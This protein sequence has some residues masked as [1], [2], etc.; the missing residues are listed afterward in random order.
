MPSN[1]DFDS[2][3]FGDLV[4]DFL[5]ESTH[6][7]GILND[8]FLEFEEALGTGLP[9]IPLEPNI[10]IFGEVFR[11]AHSIKGTSSML[12]LV[13]VSSFTHA[14][15]N[16]LDAI[17]SAR[18]DLS[19]PLLEIL[20][21]G[22]DR[23]EDML[24][25]V[26]INESDQLTDETDELSDEDRQ[27]IQW[28][29]KAVHE[30]LEPEAVPI[31]TSEAERVPL[32]T[33]AE[34]TSELDERPAEVELAESNEPEEVAVAP[35]DDALASD[36]SP[37]SREEDDQ[38]ESQAAAAHVPPKVSTSST[39]NDGD[40]GFDMSR[41]LSLYL[42]ESDEEIDALNEGLLQLE[43][44]PGDREA[45][46]EVFR[47]AH[48]IKGSATAMG[49]EDVGLV[50]H[51]LEDIFD[52]LRDG[53]G[54]IDEAGM[55]LL[56]HAVDALRD[57]HQA[58]RAETESTTDLPAIAREIAEMKSRALAAKTQP[59]PEAEATVDA[60]A[61]SP[62]DS[63]PGES[64]ELVEASEMPEESVPALSPADESTLLSET[65]P[66]D[67]IAGSEYTEVASA[68]SGDEAPTTRVN[69]HFEAGLPLANLKAELIQI[70]L[71]AQ[72]TI[73]NTIP[74]LES[75]SESDELQ[76]FTVDLC[77][78]ASE[79]ALREAL[80]V[81][82]VESVE[83]LEFDDEGSLSSLFEEEMEHSEPITTGSVQEEPVLS[84]SPSE[85]IE[86]SPPVAKTPPP[87]R[88]V[89]SPAPRQAAAGA[90][91]HGTR[92]GAAATTT[93]GSAPSPRREGS[94]VSETLRVEI[95]RLDH[96]MNLAGELVINKARFVQI[97]SGLQ[98]AFQRKASSF[99]SRGFAERLE[100][101]GKV[102]TEHRDQ[103]EPITSFDSMISE[104]SRLLDDY[105]VIEEDLTKVND[106]R[107]TFNSME[108]V[109]HELTRVSDGIQK[110]VMDTRMVPVE[111]LFVRFK[112]VVRDV[113]R[114][115]GKEVALA[116][117]GEKTELDK[118]MIDELGD[119]LIHLI[120]NA[121]D[122]GLETPE[123]RIA[124]GK[125]PRGTVRLEASHRGNSVLITVSDDGRGIN[126]DKVREKVLAHGLASEAELA[127]LSDKQMLGYIFHPGLS[128]AE[129]VTDI[130]GRGVGTDIVKSRIDEL[131][132]TIDV[133]TL[134]GLGTTFT[135]R[136]PL[137]LAIMPS[138]LTRVFGDVFAMPLEV[139]EEIVS[140]PA[141]SIHTVQGSK[142][143]TVRRRVIPLATFN[144]IFSWGGGGPHP[145]C[146]GE[147]RDT[148]NEKRDLTVVILLSGEMRIGLIVDH[149]IGEQDIV[150]KSLAE[151]FFNV[152]GLAGAS[153]L[154]DGRVSLIL[155]VGA[156]M[157]GF[158]QASSRLTA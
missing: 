11:A 150:V 148:A 47:M 145:A 13:N 114:G 60:T 81:D 8:R 149:L 91:D 137:T 116:I 49:F 121:V 113:A 144:D 122:H 55:N 152:R 65:E 98:P 64:Q 107:Q 1:Q 45:I 146:H 4:S 151:N 85:P 42:D 92:N 12:G 28:L 84:A 129:K 54:S 158:V 110:S 83:L 119:P 20:F 105:R 139:V 95:D 128:T 26:R 143:I 155:D 21:R 87:P 48:R 108:T 93:N 9:S 124:A 10:E 3:L 157:E 7:V 58:L 100:C 120:R 6:L 16:V 97:A 133:E 99:A 18:L 15:E 68:E 115:A 71:A 23:L 29:E 63:A 46:N 73:T 153:I 35:D 125:P 40:G 156:I 43:R 52:D 138:L 51:E 102:L 80:V 32:R 38:L 78:E 44:S 89:A 101:L 70:K 31:G 66:Q 126:V 25:K 136:L 82:G 72:G 135:I 75:L 19:Q 103:D 39:S 123:E 67:G 57:Y 36:R 147:H 94:K 111:P 5:D 59:D 76:T 30:A 61:D 106:A 33:D 86:A 154:G 17:R 131:S 127:Q 130:S 96:L 50:T 14:F 24:G 34:S 109:I 74:K 118:R 37:A 79:K 142:T 134:S 22:L 132:G 90:R 2:E 56:F 27:F 88:E 69:V 53:T 117:A 41:Y 77:T 141:N 62:L 140:V 112:R 104:V